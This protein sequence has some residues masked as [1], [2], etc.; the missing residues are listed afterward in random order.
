MKK[1]Y[2]ILAVILLA[3]SGA[4]VFAWLRKKEEKED[5]PIELEPKGTEEVFIEPK[6]VEPKDDS[7][8]LAALTN[9]IHIEYLK[10][11]SLEIG[12]RMQHKG[13]SYEGVFKHGDLKILIQKSFANFAVFSLKKEEKP[14]HHK[15]GLSSYAKEVEEPIVYL[16]ISNK[17]GKVVKGLKVNLRTGD[18]IEGL[19]KDWSEFDGLN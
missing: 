11:N 15:G 1:I 16:F 8:I 3:G 14:V 12:Y 18:Q 7:E 6:P 17:K 13:D 10:P 2:I 9:S 5:L 4:G 19:P